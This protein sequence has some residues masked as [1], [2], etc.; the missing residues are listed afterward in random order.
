VK[1]LSSHGDQSV[2][3]ALATSSSPGAHALCPGIYSCEAPIICHLDM[4]GKSTTAKD[5][6]ML[7]GH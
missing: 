1:L 5:A 2:Q 6:I 7:S 4:A 3:L